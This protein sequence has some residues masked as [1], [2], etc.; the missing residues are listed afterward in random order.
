MDKFEV[1]EVNNQEKIKSLTSELTKLKDVYHTTL[2]DFSRAE[3]QLKELK[4]KHQSLENNFNDSLHIKLPS[5][6]GVYN[7][8]MGVKE[9]T[10]SSCLGV[11]ND[12][13]GVKETT[14]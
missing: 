1:T 14:Q 2:L 13:T 12:I 9:T 7:D 4:D 11:Y 6:L 3:K 5:C 10:Q 8:I